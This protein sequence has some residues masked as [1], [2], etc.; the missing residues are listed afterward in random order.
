MLDSYLY[1]YDLLRF[2]KVTANILRPIIKVF[3]LGKRLFLD[4]SNLFIF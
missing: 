2:Y 4:G 3:V 1:E